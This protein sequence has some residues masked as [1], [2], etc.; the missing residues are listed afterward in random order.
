[1]SLIFTCLY[2]MTNLRYWI[3]MIWIYFFAIIQVAETVWRSSR[4]GHNVPHIVNDTKD[5]V[6]FYEWKS[7]L[8]EFFKPLKHITDYHHFFIDSKH[9]GVV[10]CKESGSSEQFTFI[11]LK[12]KTRLPQPQTI[13]NIQPLKVLIQQDSG[14]CMSISDNTAI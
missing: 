13:P 14:N 10:K 7:Y 2:W 6:I 3:K 4:N 8:Q 9:P 5:P 12:S 11:L 1:M